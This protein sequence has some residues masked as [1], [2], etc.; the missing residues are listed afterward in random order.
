MVEK[1]KVNNHCVGYFLI[2]QTIAD[3]FRQDLWIKVVIV[4]PVIKCTEF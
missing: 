4:S 2:R 3:I 1:K